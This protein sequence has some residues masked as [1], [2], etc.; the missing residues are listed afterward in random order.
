MEPEII[1]AWITAVIALLAAVF[2]AVISYISALRRQ[3]SE[4]RSL[5][6]RLEKEH[7]LEIIRLEKER[8]LEF[9]LF[10]NE[11]LEQIRI[12]YHQKMLEAYQKL[13]TL[14]APLSYY[15]EP[16]QGVIIRDET[17]VYLNCP[18]I[19]KFFFSFRD[20]FYSEYGIFLSKDF[21]AKIFEVRDFII[22]VEKGNEKHHNGWVPISNTKAK[23]I[24]NGLDWIRKN[25]RRGAGLEGDQ[26]DEL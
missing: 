8:Q 10:K 21:R 20:F 12:G 26:T 4:I 15:T 23:Q 11:Q 13:W 1:A 9:E 24:E 22:E 18:V 7:A 5:Q 2:G 17:G 14:M 16:G 6:A 19:D 3:E 25:I